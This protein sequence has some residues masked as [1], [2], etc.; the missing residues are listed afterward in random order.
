MGLVTYKQK[1][2]FNKTPEPVGGKP[3]GKAL[4]FVIQKHDASHLHYD[5]RLEMEG[6]LKSWAVPKGPSTDPAVKRLAMMVEDHPFDY[7][8]FEGIIP[9]GQYGGGTVIVWDEGSYEMVGEFDSKKEMEKALLQG[10]KKGKIHFILQGKKLKGEFA[11]VKTT[12]RGE[13]SW[14]LMKIQDKYAKETDILKKDKSVLSGKTIPQMEKTP[15]NVYGQVSKKKAEPKKKRAVRSTE[16]KTATTG[17]RMKMPESLHPMLAT[18]VEKPPEEEG[19]DYEVKWDGYRALAYCNRKKV[20]LR[21]R[22][23][24]DF[25]HKYYPIR[26]ALKELSLNAI[27]DGEL[28]VSKEN[29]VSDFGSLQNWRSEA[30]GE[31]V[32]YVFDLLWEDGESLMDLPLSERRAR[33]AELL[34]EHPLV[35]VSQVFDTDVN[36]FLEVAGKMKMEGIMAKKADSSY[37]PGA[38]TKEWL[39]IKVLNRHEV[40][41]GGYTKNEGSSKLFSS[42]LVG[43]FKKGKLQYTGKIG[44]G[45]S[46]ATQAEMLKQ[47]K[48]L[49]TKHNPFTIAPDINKPSRFRPHPPNAEAIWLKPQLVCE[50]SYTELTS[51]GIMRHPSFEGMRVDKK[52]SEVKEEKAKPVEEVT[53]ELTDNKMKGKTITRKLGKK[54]RKTLLNPTENQQ[55]KMIDG[56]DL[57]FT[58]VK[59]IYWPKEKITKGD[60]V[61]YYYQVAPYILPFMIDRPQSLNRHPNGIAGESFYQKNIAGKFPSWLKTHNY[62]NTTKEGQKKFLVCADEATL[63]YMANLGCIEMNPWHS[64]VKSPDHPDWSV[65][66]LDPDT[67]SFEEVI[68]I[69]RLVKQ[70]LESVGIK[71][72][73]KTSGSTGIHIYIPLAAKYDYE[74]SKMLAQLI[75]TMV[76]KESPGNTSLERSPA[77]RK[78]Q[79]YLDFLQNRS[80]QTIAAPFSL[81]PKPGATVSMP[82]EWEEVKKGLKVKDFTIHNAA[83]I[84]RERFDLFKPVLGKGVDLGKILDKV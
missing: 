57:T 76:H 66:D 46:S 20:E 22:N 15:D 82:L 16:Q 56:K 50:V 49:V 83:A 69:A 3:T 72:Y 2:S 61:N 6:V 38:R 78:G 21:S 36:Q 73:P 60:M 29:G 71:G 39:K 32:Y 1:R 55:V 37:F 28:I 10:L 75:V 79:I 51:D 12:G 67:N 65:I 23:D 14:L 64:N 41:I 19:W 84:A 48:P 80:I 40:V 25:S 11:L 70:A 5:F 27:L 58:N 35:R 18:L 42:L 30:D 52:A 81:R 63:L 62:K 26:D 59:K 74:Q 8:D 24:L 4:S 17:K 9:K 34:P 54:E 68:G 33:L 31:L 53:G 44:T 13:N 77:K 47:F 45:F 43:V 7:K